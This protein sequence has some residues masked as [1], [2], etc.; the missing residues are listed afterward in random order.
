MGEWGVPKITGGSLEAHREQTRSR[1]YAALSSLM[2]EHAFDAITMAQIAEAAGIGR[3]AIYNHVQDKEDLLLSFINHETAQY[4]EALRR[5]LAGVDDPVEQLRVYVRQQS[6]LRKAYRL[7]PGPDLRSM[8]SKDAQA[9]LREHADA[10]G[11]VLGEILRSG[12]ASGSLPAQDVGATVRL[13]N[14]CLTGRAVG[15]TSARRER[16]IAT[17][18][19]FVLRAVGAVSARAS[20]RRPAAR[21]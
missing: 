19:T 11:E 12:I 16:E 15:D 6:Q 10:V 14:A 4:V 13:I 18:E 2:A 3:T 8:L 9:R 20:R 17:A 21:T 5:A 7:A 1:L